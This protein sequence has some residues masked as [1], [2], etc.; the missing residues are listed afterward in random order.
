[1]KYWLGLLP[2]TIALS[3]HAA[4]PRVL[5]EGCVLELVAREPEIVTPVG[6]A[7]DS[8][9]RL[10]IVESHTHKRTDDY[11]GPGGDRIRMLA[12]LNGD[13]TLDAWSTFAEGYRHALNIAV[14]P[15]GA[16]Y[17][18]TR[19]EVHLLQ[20]TNSDGVADEDEIIVRLETEE[21][22][23]HNALSGIALSDD[24]LY[25]G[26][27]ENFGVAY[28][29]VGS[30][31]SSF[32]DHGGAGRVFRC[33]WKGEQIEPY[34]TGFWNPFSLCLA[35]ERLFAVDNDPDAM[36]PCRLIDVVE[37]A[38]YGFRFEYGRAGVHPLLAW[39][40]ELPGTLPMVCGTGEAP[41]AV[42]AHRG[43]LW[44]TSWGDHRIE[45]YE[46]S[47]QADGQLAAAMTV[48]VQG[49]SD[50][51][52]TGMAIAPDGSLV[53]GD[54][55][56]RSYPVHGKGRI[57]KLT[58]PADMN[59]G[60]PT[61]PVQTP[62]INP[63]L[64]KLVEKRWLRQTEAEQLIELLRKA[65]Q[66][67]DPDVRLFG[68]RWIAEERV[69]ELTDE[70][71]SLLRDS[72][73]SERYYM[74]V[75]GAIDWLEGEK[76]P[77]HSGIN[78]GLLARELRSSNRSDSSKA[79]ALRLISP[80]YKDLTL[81][82][83]REFLASKSAELRLE[84][85]RTLAARSDAERFGLLREIVDNESLAEEIRVEA[86]V[87]LSAAWQEHRQLFEQLSKDGAGALQQ[88][89]KRVLRLAG[90]T[91]P[92]DEEIPPASDLNA[93]EKLLAES[94]DAASGRRLFFSPVGPQCSACHRHGGRGGQVGPDLTN[95]ADGSSRAKIIE[96]IL[97]PS[98]EVA[99]HYQPMILQIDDGK[100]HVG[101]RLPKGG[102][103]GKEYYADSAGR[104][105]ELESK[106]VVLR[107][108][109]P[110]SLMPAGLEKS[111]T[112][113]DLRNLVTFLSQQP[114]IVN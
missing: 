92:V 4:E 95:L 48:V 82:R 42:I 25:L 63:A 76:K 61:G 13:G 111:L 36:P 38:D 94:G 23:P 47:K 86:V 2:L 37:R 28:R 44:V 106:S 53:F 20:D 34:A 85:V 17:V 35:K 19:G 112:V 98:R 60:I 39:D 89:A 56:D 75:L 49:E 81:D 12:D 57:W 88:E 105:F 10:L 11:K 103:D 87:G 51:R 1:M 97:D 77:R 84:A 66:S 31:G 26:L 83:L 79:L 114:A 8:E 80:D 73:P 110:I 54:W 71:N 64:E 24:G 32:S 72:P 3:T 50:F 109:S 91:R 41:T 96:S 55:V 101:L 100:T 15:D 16:V 99:P 30:D 7:F 59:A 14:R 70:V 62:A 6:V 27:G 102:D 107:Q 65:L 5:V 108:P 58:L 33:G 45:R 40:G 46:L 29:L 69:T 52:P 68:V 74:A 113:E 104:R 90:Q 9:G 22:Y 67:S 43:Y 93:W 21:E 18:V 78:D